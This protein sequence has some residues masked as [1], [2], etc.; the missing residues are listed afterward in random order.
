MP[1]IEKPVKLLLMYG[2]KQDSA[3]PKRLKVKLEQLGVIY[4]RISSDHWDSFVTT[5]NW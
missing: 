1:I 5:F 2:G 4:S 3:T